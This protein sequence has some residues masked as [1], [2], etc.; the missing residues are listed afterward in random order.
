[1]NGGAPDVKMVRPDRPTYVL[2][3]MPDLEDL[4]RQEQ[5]SGFVVK[6]LGVACTLLVVFDLFLLA[7]RMV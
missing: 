1:M 3:P 6:L 4:E 5:A 7:G 2:P